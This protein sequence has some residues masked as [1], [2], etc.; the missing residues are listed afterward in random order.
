MV[1][2]LKLMVPDVGVEAR[3]GSASVRGIARVHLI[4]THHISSG[5]ALVVTAEVR[6]LVETGLPMVFEPRN[7]LITKPGLYLQDL[8]V[9]LVIH[10]S[11]GETKQLISETALGVVEQCTEPKSQYPELAVPAT[12]QD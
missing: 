5:N 2:P 4:G 11:T 9:C 10:N 1:R 7:A 3:G 8:R 12:A 6:G